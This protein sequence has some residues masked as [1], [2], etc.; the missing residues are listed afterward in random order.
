MQVETEATLFLH[1]AV[2][3]VVLPQSVTT[4]LVLLVVLEVL[5]MTFL[6]LSLAVHCLRVAV[7]V[8]EELRVVLVVAA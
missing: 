8:A 4:S 2:E 6:R 1:S 5:A 3:V 7:V